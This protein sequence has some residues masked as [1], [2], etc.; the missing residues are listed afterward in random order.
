[1]SWDVKHQFYQT[2]PLSLCPWSHAH[3]NMACCLFCTAENLS[4][5]TPSICEVL[6]R[7]PLQTR[8]LCQKLNFHSRYSKDKGYLGEFCMPQSRTKHWA[9]ERTRRLLDW[10]LNLVLSLHFISLN[11]NNKNIFISVSLLGT[12]ILCRQIIH[13]RMLALLL[14]F[15]VSVP[16]LPLIVKDG[17]KK[18][19]LCIFHSETMDLK[20]KQE[21]P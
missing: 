7:K 17:R 9:P 1:M 5:L 8:L 6:K 21:H 14:L 2:G 13:Y 19:S 16:E 3:E 15:V 10:Y 12:V 11:L 20:T 18:S 4:C